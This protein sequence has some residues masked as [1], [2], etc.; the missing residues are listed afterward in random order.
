MKIT[1]KSVSQ[2]IVQAAAVST[3]A[4]ALILGG[5]T[6][7]WKLGAKEVVC[8]EIRMQTA[9]KPDTIQVDRMIHQHTDQLADSLSSVKRSIEYL[10]A[11]QIESMPDSV[12]RK[13]NRRFIAQREIAGGRR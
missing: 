2:H 13:V 10:A 6:L 9:N 1:M 5:G 3:S 8:S 11:L 12:L 7:I 4:M